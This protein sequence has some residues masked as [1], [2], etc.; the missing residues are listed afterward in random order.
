MC[1]R[2]TSLARLTVRLAKRT[3]SRLRRT[4]P[5]FSLDACPAESSIDSGASA[6]LATAVQKRMLNPLDHPFLIL[7]ISLPTF[8][9]FALT[10][11]WLHKRARDFG[12]DSHDDFQFV[13][14]GTLTLLALIVGFTFSMAVN[15]Y[16]QRK[17]YEE[18]EANAIGTEYVRADLLPSADG[19]RS[20]PCCEAIS[21]SAY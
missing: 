15:R 12:Q 14:G 5:Q 6:T 7:A 17:N 18:Q 1:S 2:P 19:P 16:D 11:A 9:L 8:W 10:G 13:L 4:R 21:I 3:S 20:A